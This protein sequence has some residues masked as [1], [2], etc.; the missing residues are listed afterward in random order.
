MSS[1]SFVS[2]GVLFYLLYIFNIFVTS[3]SMYI[4]IMIEQKKKMEP[5]GV[6][7]YLFNPLIVWNNPFAVDVPLTEKPGG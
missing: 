5:F 2:C 7:H 3:E 1:V 6:T 4:V